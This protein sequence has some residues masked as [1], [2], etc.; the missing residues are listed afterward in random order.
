MS[1]QAAPREL[2]GEW[3]EELVRTALQGPEAEWCQ[4][5]LEKYRA[6]L[7]LVDLKVSPPGVALGLV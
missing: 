3:S 4:A 2:R 7:A 1:A 6:A 5:S